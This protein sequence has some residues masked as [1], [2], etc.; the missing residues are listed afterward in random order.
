MSDKMRWRY[1]ETNPVIAPVKTETVIEIGDLVF[2]DQDRLY[3]ATDI[4]RLAAASD[5][6][7]AYSRIRFLG[8][9]MQRCILGEEGSI[10][11]ATTG[12]FEYELSHDRYG[13]YGAIMLGE[14]VC[15]VWNYQEQENVRIT[16]N[17]KVMVSRSPFPVIGIIA[18]RDPNPKAET[19]FVKIQSTIMNEW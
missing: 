18:K 17:Q 13:D 8:V 4:C 12:V 7:F 5:D 14:P 6:V 19:V 3:P 1:G 15:T 10:R 16:E 2:Y 9:A 11:V